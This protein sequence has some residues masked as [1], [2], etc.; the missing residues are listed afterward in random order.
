MFA[1]AG[2]EVK[3]FTLT[4]QLSPPWQLA[5]PAWRKRLRPCARSLADGPL[6]R[7]SNGELGVRTAK[8]THSR[9][10]VNAGTLV[11]LP[12]NVTVTCGR[13]ALARAKALTTLGAA[14]RSPLSPMSRP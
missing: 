5:Q 11:V 8:R 7:S 12:G 10:A 9:S 14:L 1:P 4:V 6:G 2:G 3:F 13:S